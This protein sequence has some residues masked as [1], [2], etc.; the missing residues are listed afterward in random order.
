MRPSGVP[1]IIALV[2]AAQQE[3]QNHRDGKRWASCN[4]YN[5]PGQTAEGQFAAGLTLPR[6][7]ALASVD[8]TVDDHDQCDDGA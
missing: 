1:A 2:Q 8:L 7:S 6:S 4:R 3:V 5:T